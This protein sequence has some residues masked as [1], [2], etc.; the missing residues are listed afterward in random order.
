M[1]KLVIGVLGENE[2]EMGRVVHQKS[3]VRSLW[4]SSVLYSISSR[5]LLRKWRGDEGRE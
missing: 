1:F 3:F 4:V 5:V 2:S